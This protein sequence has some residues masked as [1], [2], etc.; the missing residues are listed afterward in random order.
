MIFIFR[1]YALCRVVCHDL[2]AYESLLFAFFAIILG[3]VD[4]IFIGS[5]IY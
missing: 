3:F 2:I 4:G 5:D 1:G